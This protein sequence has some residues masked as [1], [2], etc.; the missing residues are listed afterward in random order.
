MIRNTKQRD[1]IHR[2][3]LEAGRPLSA[4]EVLTSACRYAPGL[5]IATV[6]RTLNG[7]GR[8]HP[9]RAAP[10]REPRRG[11]ATPPSFPLRRLRACL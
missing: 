11:L 3:I 9:R 10:V 2:A 6:Y 8:A 7:G 5:G 1:A 4:A